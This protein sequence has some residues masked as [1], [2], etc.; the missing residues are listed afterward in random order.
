M[1]FLEKQKGL[2]E[3]FSQD[4]INLEIYKDRAE[5]LRNEEK[6][7]RQDIRGVQLKILDKR[8]TINLT[9]AT[10]DFLLHLRKNS[11]NSQMDFLVKTFMRIIFKAV[12]IQNQEIVTFELNEPW[13]TCYDER[14][15]WN[16]TPKI[17][18]Q[19]AAPSRIHHANSACYWRPTA[20]R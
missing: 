19:T 13:Q 5:L 16:N 8:N 7:L 15:R 2:Y 1:N 18:Q 20:A 11:D 14:I 3:V 9:R 6:K 10:Q 12:Y 4:S 17:S